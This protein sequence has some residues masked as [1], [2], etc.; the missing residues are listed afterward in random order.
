MTRMNHIR[1]EEIM[2]HGLQQR[3]VIDVVSDRREL[4]SEGDEEA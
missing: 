2:R 4:E 1:N 3:L